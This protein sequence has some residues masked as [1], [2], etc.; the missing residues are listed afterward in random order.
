MSV[1]RVEEM[2]RGGVEG[3]VDTRRDEVEEGI[4][5]ESERGAAVRAR[6]TRRCRICYN[7][8]ERCRGV[9]DG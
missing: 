9:K 8:G 6:N 7:P 5:D 4:E 3:C 2:A 1:P